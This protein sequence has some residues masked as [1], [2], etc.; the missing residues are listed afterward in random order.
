MWRVCWGVVR[1]GVWATIEKIIWVE[2]GGAGGVPVPVSVLV[3]GLER[4]G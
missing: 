2:G 4:R 3:M 1:M